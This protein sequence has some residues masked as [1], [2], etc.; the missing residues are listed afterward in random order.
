[1]G[2]LGALTWAPEPEHERR[3]K[4]LWPTFDR[5]AGESEIPAHILAAVGIQESDLRSIQNLEGAPAFGIMQIWGPAWFGEPLEDL[6]HGP[7]VTI[8][9]NNWRDPLT[10]VRT[11]AAVLVRYGALD[12]ATPWETVLNR[13]HGDRD[14]SIDSYEK[15][16]RTM[17]LGLLRARALA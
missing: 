17:A 6:P 7:V 2:L 8:T 5:V 11:G 12:P 1:M 13:Y 15:N 16:I 4:E 9:A 10:N 3:L 14:D